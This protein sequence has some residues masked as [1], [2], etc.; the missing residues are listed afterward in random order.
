MKLNFM[1]NIETLISEMMLEEKAA[2]CTGATAWTT[3]PIA[4]LEIPGIH[5]ADGP[6]GIRKVVKSES[7]GHETLEATC[8]PTASCLAS[9]W[10]LD[11]LFEMGQAIAEEAIAL[12]VDIVLGP[13]VNM[14]RIPT[15]GRNFEYYSED[16]FLSGEMAASFING[17]QK[18]GVGTSLKH[19]AAN[20]QETLR[21]IIDAKIDERTLHEI[22]LTAFEI[23]VKKA[24]PW[25]VMCAYNRINDVYGSENRYLM[26]E[27]LKNQWRFEGFVVS[28]WN[29]VHNR[30][31]SLRAG[32]D[33]EMPGPR[34]R[35]VQEVIDAVRSG[36]LD[37]P[38]LNEAVRRILRIVFKSAST[39]NG[40]NF[41][42]EAHHTLARKIAGEGIVLLKNNGILP[43]K[44]LTN[45]AVIGRSAKE[46]HFQGGGS[47]HINPTRV[48]VP[49]EELEKLAG[50]ACI[51]YS[52]G[53]PADD[54]TQPG[55][56]TS[57]VET[58]QAAEVAL[59]YIALPPYIEAE[60]YDRSD[61]DLTD[62]QIKLIKSVT[63]VQP[64][65]VVI[66]NNGSAVTMNSWI[67]GVAAVLEGWMMGQAGGGAI[68]D[69]LFGHVNPSGKLTETFPF[70]LCDTPAYINFPGEQGVVRYGE[71]MFIGYRYYDTCHQPNLFPFGYGK[72]YTTF[73]FS[74]SSVSQRV[75]RDIDGVTISV[76]VTN[77]GDMPGKEVVQVYIHDQV[78]SLM[79]PS[80]E[81]KGFAKVDLQSG[82]TKT[83]SI[84]LDF[85]AF[86][87]YHPGYGQWIT[88]SG[89][90]DLLVGSSSA[91]IHIVEKVTLNSTL[92]LPCILN[93]RS[94]I[95][96][97]I[98]D[99][100]GNVVFKPVYKKIIES[101]RG[102]EILAYFKD[103]PLIEVLD[104]PEFSTDIDPPAILEQLLN[105]IQD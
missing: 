15:C 37:E 54:S 31:K 6:H 87:F 39:I 29:A 62:Q 73:S 33:L 30:V 83:V 72:S 105:Q 22:Y 99:P 14:K 89:E 71:G 46:A 101:P 102:K 69:V 61:L 75:F 3:T 50:N 47:S 2:L 32:L 63:T 86:A 16:P 20:N 51:S 64:N 35:R 4:R 95:N 92:G 56:I 81:L 53:Y 74:N 12:N 27:I 13:G 78:S 77:T 80:K 23:A 28:D 57:A 1:K 97:W 19:F 65:T 85:R 45:I 44:N 7:M 10:N 93:S 84:N 42:K 100:H 43:L 40:K 24:Q 66:L 38:V 9:S 82:E 91:D 60:G 18:M 68:A 76:D 11:L 25:T 17:V 48:D 103:L 67:E 5:V 41:D 70:Q 94:S 49:L 52:E 104:L 55:M 90:F 98:Q 96:D 26:K 21:M 79:R 59:L 88:E 36:Q 58:A 34:E 8:F